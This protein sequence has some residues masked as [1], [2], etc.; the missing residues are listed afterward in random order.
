MSTSRTMVRLGHVA[1]AL[2]LISFTA[3]QNGDAE[4]YGTEDSIVRVVHDEAGQRVDVTVSGQPFT[5]YLYTDTIA[6]LKKPVL[7]PIHAPTGAM[8]TRGYPLDPKPG[9]RTD[10]P[11]QI[12][13]WFNYGDVNGLD[14]WN[15]S[16]AIPAER[17]GQM[18][19]IR[20]VSVDATESGNGTGTLD[21][22]AHWV[23]P[24]DVVLLEEK[25][26][27]VFTAQPGMWIIDRIT[28][29]TAQDQAVSFNDNKE[30]VL[31]LRVTRALEMP[32]EQ[33]IE[34]TD[35]SGAVTTVPVLDNEG[36]TGHY[37]NSEGIEGYPDVWGKRA[38]WTKLSGVVEGDSVTV[39]IL[40]HPQN[41]GFPTYWHARDY[42]LFAANPLGQSALSNGRETLN[43]KLGAGESTTFRYRILVFASHPSQDEV[44][45]QYARWAEGS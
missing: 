29:L 25:T 38:R 24:E 17:A 5:S 22:T 43:F 6:V 32:T 23:T 14:F 40:D 41:V 7:Y 11:H 39:A 31:G 37:A 20:H 34:L 18:G 8:I 35:A 13:L 12:G 30:G 28:Q 1:V 33:P 16:D 3:C 19:T 44:E 4:T 26:R 45:A 15:N 27:Y 9:E 21:V 2:L 36:V 42:G 10:H